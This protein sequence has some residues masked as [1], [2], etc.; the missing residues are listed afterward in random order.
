MTV[1]GEIY[2]IKGVSTEYQ[3]IFLDKEHRSPEYEGF[4]KQLFKFNQS[5]KYIGKQHDDVPDALASLVSNVLEVK[6][7]KSVA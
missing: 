1:L 2:E 6:I 5:A 3:L 4:M 7:S